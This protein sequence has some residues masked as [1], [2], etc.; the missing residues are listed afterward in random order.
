MKQSEMNNAIRIFLAVLLAGLAVAV[1]SG[2]N[3]QR[4]TTIGTWTPHLS[5]E[6]VKQIIRDGDYFYCNTQGGYFYWNTNTDEFK[7]YSPIDGLSDV[8]ASAMY[9]DSLSGYI[10]LGYENGAINYFK[11]PFGQVNYMTDI[12]RTDLFTSKRINLFASRDNLLYIA[13][14]FGVVIFD[15]EKGETKSSVTKVGDLPTGTT[16]NDMEIVEDTLYLCMSSGGL[17]YTHL[18][19]PNITVPTVWNKADGNRGMVEGAADQVTSIGTTVYAMVGDTSYTKRKGGNWTVGPLPH[20]DYD[21]FEAND[22]LL[23]CGYDQYI[24]VHKDGDPQY[25][26]VNDHGAAFAYLDSQYT[27]YSDPVT[28]LRMVSEDLDTF[29]EIGPDGPQTN[30]LTQIAVG[31]GEIF[32]APQGQAGGTSVPL[33]EPTGFH[34]FKQGEGWHNFNVEDEISRDSI[35]KDIARLHYDRET[36]TCY[37]GSWSQGVIKFR[38]DSI[39]NNFMSTNS[40]LSGSYTQGSG[41]DTRVSGLDM[42]SDGNLWISAILADQNLNLLTA[43]GEWYQ[44]NLPGTFPVDLLVD[45]WG[46]KWVINNGLGLTVF[47]ENGTFDVTSDDQRKNLSTSTGNGG[48]PSGNVNAIAK[49]RNGHIWVGTLEGIA[50]YANPSRVFQSNFSD[51]SCPVIDG[52][53]LLRNQRVTAIAVDGANRKWIGTENGVYVVNP[54]GNRL[55]EHITIDNSPLFSNEIRDIEIDP[56]T[57]EIF[58]ATSKG[59]LSLMGES[60]KGKE[61]SDSLYVFPNPIYTDF[62]GPIAIS[63]SVTDAEVRITTASGMVVRELDALGGQAVW[64]GRDAAGNRLA[65]GIYLAMVADKEGNGAGI[66]KFA[67]VSRNP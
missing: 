45:D 10:F 58:F 49:D 18:D 63:C 25:L 31:N 65:P 52:F 54:Q 16:V 19:Q 51:A 3:A 56:E 22:S 4:T 50:V 29:V 28:T 11:K 36:Q 42:D 14:D 23:Y 43:D 55:I 15:I 64:D 32:I 34:Y 48:L 20:R 39:L 40:G 38:N 33:G 8:D 67:V 9:L 59:L 53:C 60:I 35:Y 26:I 27:L 62:D 30:I 12:K 7:T 24:R 6:Y 13:T 17:Y 57:G 61:E 21:F 44:Y 37:F 47:N 46:N 2:G 5:Y 1:P 66:A 41:P